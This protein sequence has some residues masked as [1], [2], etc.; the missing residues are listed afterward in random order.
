MPGPS[1]TCYA[2][3]ASAN[4]AET[5]NSDFKLWG[6]ESTIGKSLK[7]GELFRCVVIVSVLCFK[8]VKL[9]PLPSIHRNA[10]GAECADRAQ[11]HAII[12]PR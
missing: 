1:V 8:I 5:S 9:H 6:N 2:I 11:P 12:E 7:L 3:I 4:W 10:V